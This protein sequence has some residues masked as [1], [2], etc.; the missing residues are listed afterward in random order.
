MCVLAGFVD[1]AFAVFLL[2]QILLHL[3]LVFWLLLL[4]SALCFHC[5]CLLL[6]SVFSFFFCFLCFS[7]LHLFGFCNFCWFF[8]FVRTF[9]LLFFI[10]ARQAKNKHK[11]EKGSGGGG[12][13]VTSPKTPPAFKILK[14]DSFTLQLYINDKGNKDI[15]RCCEST[16]FLTLSAHIDC[17]VQPYIYTYI[18]TKTCTCVYMCKHT[19]EVTFTLSYIAMPLPIL[20]IFIYTDMQIY[21]FI[22]AYII[23]I[24]PF[25]F[26]C[27]RIHP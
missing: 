11:D 5:V 2:Y 16:S 23:H 13:A 1:F 17:M 10:Q 8:V 27:I 3:L 6:V 18:H 22:E 14:V 19:L 20:D 4:L 25:V 24:F 7:F 12:G 21:I 15:N 26:H 9:F